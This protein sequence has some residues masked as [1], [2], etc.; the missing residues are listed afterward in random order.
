MTSPIFQNEFKREL[1]EPITLADV[2]RIARKLIASGNEGTLDYLLKNFRFEDNGPVRIDHV[3]DN[4]ST[5]N[6]TRT[7]NV[8]G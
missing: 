1:G 6:K 5:G 3:G 7:Q 4:N 8:K 2:N